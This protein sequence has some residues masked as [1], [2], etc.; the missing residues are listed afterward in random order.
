MNKTNIP[1]PPTHA[2]DWSTFR[3]LVDAEDD[4]TIVRFMADPGTDNVSGREDSHEGC[5]PVANDAPLSPTQTSTDPLQFWDVDSDQE[6]YTPDTPRRSLRLVGDK[7]NWAT[8]DAF[9]RK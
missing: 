6:D 3:D 4:V 5:S 9:G 8:Y 7:I 1:K 2:W